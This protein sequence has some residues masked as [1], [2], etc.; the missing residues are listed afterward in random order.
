MRGLWPHGCP[1][2]GD[3]GKVAEAMSHQTD[4]AHKGARR[5]AAWYN[6][7]NAAEQPVGVSA[8]KGVHYETS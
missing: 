6:R 1:D 5:N 4:A 2:C 7:W 3:L 8:R